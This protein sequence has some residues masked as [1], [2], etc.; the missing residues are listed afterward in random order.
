M[1][2]I[3]HHQTPAQKRASRVRAKLFGTADRPRLTVFRSQQ[4]ISVQVIDDET[5]KTL[6]SVSDLGKDNKMKGTKT[7]RATEVAQEL[8]TQL[9]KNKITK[10]AFDRGAYKYHGR[11]KAVAVALREGG[12]EV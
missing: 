9:K 7:E 1:P 5:Q 12:I 4:H 10:L 11:V 3:K 8:L 6:I 2:V